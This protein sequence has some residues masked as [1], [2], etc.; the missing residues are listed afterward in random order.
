M[1]TFIGLLL[2]A[3]L[4]TAE[5]IRFDN[6]EVYSLGVKTIEQLEALRNIENS[7]NDGYTFWNT[8][9]LNRTLDLMVSPEK[10]SEFLKIVEELNLSHD[11][12]IENV[13]T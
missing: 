12:K 9:G 8:L 5:K 10:R 7:P 11:L 1:K 6:H 3:A 4:V 2:L 13:Q